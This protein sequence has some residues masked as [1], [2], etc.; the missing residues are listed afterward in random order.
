MMPSS[1]IF[2]RGIGRSNFFTHIRHKKRTIAGKH[3]GFWVFPRDKPCPHP[4]VP[5]P[6]ADPALGI[7][8]FQVFRRQRDALARARPRTRHRFP[9][10]ASG[11]IPLMGFSSM[12]ASPSGSV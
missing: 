7:F 10:T 2:R 5:Q 3:F 9:A 1:I 11:A 4:L 12:F 6:R 8:L